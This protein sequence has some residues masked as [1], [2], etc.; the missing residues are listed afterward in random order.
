MMEEDG[1]NIIEM[2]IEGEKA[3]SGLVRPDF[4]LVIV[5]ARD[6]KR[7]CLVEV[8]TTDGTIVLLEAIN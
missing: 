8:D 2:A 7:L 3:S 1:S 5:T 6:E 4:D